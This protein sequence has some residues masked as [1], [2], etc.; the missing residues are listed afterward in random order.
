MHGKFAFLLHP[1]SMEH[2]Y[3]AKP[4]A[5]YLP[6]GVVNWYM[7]MKKPFVASHITGIESKTGDTAEGWFIIVPLTPELMLADDDLATA[8][9]IEAGR[10]AEELGA[11]IMGLGAFTAI[12]GGAGVKAAEALDIGVTTGNSFTAYTA[13]EALMLAAKEVGLDPENDPDLK[14]TVVGA[15]GSI[16]RIVAKL[17]A[18]KFA[19]TIVAVGRDPE[20]T[21]RVADEIASVAKGKVEHST[22]A[23]AAMRDADL[24]VT[25]S[26]SPVALI[27]PE[28]V[29]SGA[30]IVDVS[31]PR[32]VAEAVGK[33]E[34]V[35]VLDGGVVKV[36]GN[37]KFNF[38]FGFPPGTAFAC[39]AET[40]M[41]AL[42]GWKDDFSLTKELKEEQVFLTG[43]LAKKH[44]FEIIWM[45]SFDLPV[46][47][48]KI[49]TIREIIS[50][51]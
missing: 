19:G 31:R 17:I 9:V 35:L 20:R 48:E 16:G 39:M 32:N 2:V 34:D 11:H 26:S 51:R 43:Q 22:D 18:P 25:V 8:K 1:L 46:S 4:W 40:M 45:R 6:K 41:L 10:I 37:V 33:R 44:G 50:K 5:R 27:G 28:D 42:E 24:G 47:R 13:A 38:D 7:K 30:I 21:R 3:K 36:P 29:K 15:T 14:L 49:E 23:K 12:V